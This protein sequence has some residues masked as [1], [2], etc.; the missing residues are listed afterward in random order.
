VAATGDSLLADALPSVEH[1]FL[2][3]TGVKNF[4]MINLT[5]AYYQIPLS[6]KRRKITAFCSHQCVYTSLTAKSWRTSQ[7]IMKK[8]RP[9]GKFGNDA[10]SCAF[11]ILKRYVFP[12]VSF[13]G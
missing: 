4:S 7:S 3:F 9:P 12:A 10:A 1:S 8:I 13:V 11:R 5:L 2:N 6:A